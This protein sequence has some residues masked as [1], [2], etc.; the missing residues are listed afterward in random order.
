MAQSQSDIFSFLITP[1]FDVSKV[2]DA[3]RTLENKIKNVSQNISNELFKAFGSLPA[4]LKSSDFNQIT[5]YI[6]SLGGTVQRNGGIITASFKDMAGNIITL[7]QNI[8]DA[9]DT[10]ERFWSGNAKNQQ[11]IQS[12]RNTTTKYTGADQVKEQQQLEQQIIKS[13]QERY[14]LENKII[15]AKAS[16]NTANEQYYTALRNI[17]ITEEQQYQSQYQGSQTVINSTKQQLDLEQQLYQQKVNTQTA[18]NKATQTEQNNLKDSLDLLSQYQSVKSKLDA[19]EA[20][21]GTGSEYYKALDSQLNDIITKMDKYGLLVSQNTGNVIFDDT[22]TSAVKAAENID[23]VE[24]NIEKT[25]NALTTQAAKQQDVANAEAKAKQEQVD[26][27]KRQKDI[28]AF[29]SALNKLISTKQKLTQLEAQGKTNTEEYKVL[30]TQY[31][32]A[33]LALQKFGAA[34]SDTDVVVT[35]HSQIVNGDAET[36]E[37]LSTK[38]EDASEKLKIYDAKAKDGAS[39]SNT[40]SQSIQ[41]SVENFIKYQVAMEAINKITSEFTSAIYDMNQAMT[42]V[43]MVTMGSYEDTVAL[44]DSYTK[45]AKQLGTTTTTVAEGADAWLRQGYNAQEAMEMLKQSTTLAVVGQLD[46]SEA[47]DQLTAIT[48]S[49]NVA[50]EDTSKIVDKLVQVDLSYAASTGEISTALQKVASSAGQAGVG[51][52]KLIGLITISE[53]K[54]RQ[55]PEVIGSAWQSIISRISKITAKVD[56]D[57]LVDEQGITHTINDADKVLSKYGITLVDTNGKMREIGT[58]LDEIGAKWNNMSTLEQNQ[59]AYVV[60]GLSKLAYKEICRK[61]CA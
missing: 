14:N 2:D 9:Y 54:T 6:E 57:D 59:L 3:S 27:E 37:K 8:S 56:L 32:E 61:Q 39:S 33:K 25:N 36:L 15:D 10:L 48:K 40:F 53:E 38:C 22:V 31:N 29:E 17:A 35:K 50:V 18:A 20:K 43:R 30:T 41:S 28:K 46:A 16:G 44:A 5:K 1:D 58:V 52:D 55:A 24:K 51:L 47:T 34:V 13:L 60:A 23:K 42:Q 26:Y 7:K 49:Y 4:G 21:N 19:E 12:L 11:I 45:L